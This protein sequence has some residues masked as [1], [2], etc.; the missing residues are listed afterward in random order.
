MNKNR[1]IPETFITFDD[2]VITPQSFIL[3]VRLSFLFS[4][5]D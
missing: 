4:A 2:C 5:A 3:A 1:Q